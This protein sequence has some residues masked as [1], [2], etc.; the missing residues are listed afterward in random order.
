MID[1]HAH[2]FP[3]KIA[4]KTVQH[5]E[6]IC[7]TPSFSDGTKEKLLKSMDEAGI[8]CSVL[9]PVLTSPAQFDSV[10]R[11]VS[12]FTEGRLISFGG[13]HPENED[14]KEKLRLIRDYGLKGIKMHSDYQNTYFSD[15]RYKRIISYAT[16]LGLI[17]V[18]H[19]GQDPYSPE[20]VHCTPKMI[21]DLVDEVAPE[22]LVLAHF[23][24]HLMTE[25]VEKY[26]IGKNVYFDTAYDLDKISAYQATKIIRSHG[27]ERILFGTDT[28][29]AS[30]KAFVDCFN[31]LP[32]TDWEKKLILKQN[33]MKLLKDC[34]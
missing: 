16:E 26:L 4:N 5:L 28:P 12:Q 33:A 6:S 17:C 3:D 13:I 10:L 15:I 22:K 25:D 11:F 24:G 29:W 8:E 20:N 19:A 21:S 32:L 34:E 18:I 14:Y 2:I 9:L 7:G 1:F 27:A 31:R 30:Q 23:G